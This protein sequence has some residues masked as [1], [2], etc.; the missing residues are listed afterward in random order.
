M[1]RLSINSVEVGFL[2]AF[3][4]VLTQTAG[5]A[6]EKISNVSPDGR[7]AMSV[8]DRGGGDVIT[9]LVEV[10]TQKFLS[11][12]DDNGHPFC[13]ADRILWSPDSKRFAFQF[14]D[15]RGDHTSI[16]VRKGSDFEEVELPNIPDCDHP[17]LEGYI[18]DQFTAKN[19]VKPDTLML[20]AH[21]EW[22]SKDGKSH[23]CDRTITIAINSNGKAS[24]KS[25]Q[26]SNAK[27]EKN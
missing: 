14:T 10:K 1:P 2:S 22:D 11:K 8:D 24:V 3:L 27:D 25:I 9:S 5:V 12:L 26:K 7:F 20:I 18:I 4:M 13:D 23:E 6:D 21:S 19:W 16:Y 17:G 15:R